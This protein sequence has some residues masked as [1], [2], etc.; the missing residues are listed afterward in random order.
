MDAMDLTLFFSQLVNGL[1]L[2]SI[3]ALIAL[4]YSMVYGIIKLLNFAHGDVIM[5]GG[6]V[7]LFSLGSGIHPIFSATLAIAG[8]VVLAVLIYRGAY[9]PLGSNA[10][11]ISLLITAIGV[12]MLLQ[13]LA[14][15]FFSA[16][17]HS[18]PANNMIPLVNYSIGG[19]NVS[20]AS[21]M[22]IIVAVA[23]MFALTI[24][25]HKTKTGKAMRAVSEDTEAA[26]LMGVNVKKIIMFTFAIGAALAGIG[27]ILYSVR[28]PLVSPTM[29]ALPGLKAFIAAVLGGIGSIPGA[30]IG[31]F[32]IGLFEVLVN[33]L[34]LSAWTDGVVFAILIVVLLVRPTGFMGPSMLEKV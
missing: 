10:P 31:G 4:G 29:G 18:F 21:I 14:Q 33:A 2:G 20:L 7:A 6:Y 32:A 27:A 12:S 9:S 16:S 8:C 22:T 13:N 24:L 28:F 11:R 1:Q 17:A 5:V 30:M 3:Y 34:G 23:S 26:Q 19:I 15:L 25:V